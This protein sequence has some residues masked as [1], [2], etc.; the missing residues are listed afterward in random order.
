MKQNINSIDVDNKLVSHYLPL[1]I[2]GDKEHIQL[3]YDHETNT[4]KISLHE[5]LIRRLNAIENR[6]DSLESPNG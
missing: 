6:I 5:D 3:S 4:L 1:K 2:E